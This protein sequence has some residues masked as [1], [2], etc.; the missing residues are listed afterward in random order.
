MFLKNIL[1]CNF[2]SLISDPSETSHVI[3]IVLSVVSSSGC[4]QED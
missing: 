3:S 1:F 4:A 2:I